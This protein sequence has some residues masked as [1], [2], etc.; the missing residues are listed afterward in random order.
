MMNILL[1]RQRLTCNIQRRGVVLSGPS[2][3]AISS[4]LKPFQSTTASCEQPSSSA[5]QAVQFK[6]VLGSDYPM[7]DET[8]RRKTVAQRQV[9][10]EARFLTV[11]EPFE[12]QRVVVRAEAMSPDKL[13]VELTDGRVQQ[14][15]IHNLQGDGHNITATITET[16]DGKQL[17]SETTEKK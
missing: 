8:Q 12:S 11:I 3:Q 9:G 1:L 2:P 15:E 7:G 5:I 10:K 6:C 4:R 17:R 13:R 14:I 16:R